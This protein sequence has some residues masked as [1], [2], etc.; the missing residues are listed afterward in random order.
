MCDMYG[1][2]KLNR[3]IPELLVNV[4]LCSTA[5]KLS[6]QETPHSNMSVTKVAGR[7][8]EPLEKP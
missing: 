1:A 4:L 3:Q 6:F 2:T 8:Q 7:T 5:F